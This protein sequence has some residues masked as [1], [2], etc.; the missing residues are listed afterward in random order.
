MARDSKGNLII[1][2]S[3]NEL[4]GASDVGNEIGEI[5]SITRNSLENPNFSYPNDDAGFEAFKLNSIS[6]LEY[7]RQVNASGNLK[8]EIIPDIEGWTNYIGITKNNAELFANVRILGSPFET[9]LEYTKITRI[10]ENN[11]FFL[12]KKDICLNG[13]DTSIFVNKTFSQISVIAK[14]GECIIVLHL[15]TTFNNLSRDIIYC[16][17]IIMKSVV[18]GAL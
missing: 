8:T 6:Y 9:M 16:K 15:P 1:T 10:T 7:V 2:H 11:H 13:W 4:A 3:E 17:D 14:F 5:I 12:Y 18:F